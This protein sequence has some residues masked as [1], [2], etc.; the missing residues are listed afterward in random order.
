MSTAGSNVDELGF[1]V[2]GR[3]RLKDCTGGIGGDLSSGELCLD[4]L[5]P[6]VECWVSCSSLKDR[7]RECCGEGCRA[8]EDLRGRELHDGRWR[9]WETSKSA[10]MEEVSKQD[11]PILVACVTV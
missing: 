6:G 1:F 9:V 4:L 2:E 5:G 10:K 7:G 3:Y 8:E 11:I